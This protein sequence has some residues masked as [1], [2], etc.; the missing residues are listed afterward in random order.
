MNVYEFSTITLATKHHVLQHTNC[1]NADY[2]VS[3]LKTS[4]TSVY[5]Y[6]SPGCILYQWR[7]T[8]R[9]IFNQLD[10]LKLV[11]C[12]ESLG[13]ISIDK[14]LSVG[15]CQ[16]FFKKDFPIFYLSSL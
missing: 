16:V 8:D 14:N 3:I 15:R 2:S 4:G 13:S 12:S 11:P 6:L 10:C 9:S 1:T 5:S 7:V